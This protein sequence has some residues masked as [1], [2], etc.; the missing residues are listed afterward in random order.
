MHGAP[1][2]SPSEIPMRAPVLTL[3]S[4]EDSRKWTVYGAS[5]AQGEQAAWEWVKENKP[6]FT[7]NAVLPNANFGRVG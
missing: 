3:A 5:K 6:S 4:S 2:H 1:L 7:F